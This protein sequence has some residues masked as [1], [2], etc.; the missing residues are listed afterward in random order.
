M[1]ALRP[2]SALLGGL[3]A[4]CLSGPVWSD[5]LMD[6]GLFRRDQP[7]LT[8]LLAWDGRVITEADYRPYVIDLEQ[9]SA[10]PL[11][12]PGGGLIVGL[13]SNGP[14]KALAQCDTDQGDS[15]RAREGDK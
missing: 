3:A 15:L 9:A 14:D 8:R 7:R 12:L 6:A 11:R 1:D 13:A 2:T 5:P 4:L 10:A